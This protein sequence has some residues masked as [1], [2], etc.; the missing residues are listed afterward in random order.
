[1]VE[2][3]EGEPILVMDGASSG[4]VEIGH[5]GILGS[6]LAKIIVN[7]K[8][9]SNFYLYY[10]L[11]IKQD[12]INQNTTGTSIPHTDKAR[13]KRFKIFIPEER[14]LKQFDALCQFL[15]AKTINAKKETKNL[16]LTRDSLL[17]RLMSGK[18]RV[19]GI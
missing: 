10:F 18:I 5:N 13:I 16:I 14:I 15:L 17:P 19:W 11:R 1:M 6:T 4:R 8:S 9:I 7:N 2:V 3:K 12:E